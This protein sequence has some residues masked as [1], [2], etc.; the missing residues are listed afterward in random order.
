MRAC[1]VL[2]LPR[3]RG[4][5]AV[6]VA[7]VLGAQAAAGGASA[8]TRDAALAG[9]FQ[10]V[11]YQGYTF[12]VLRNWPVIRL[13]SQPDACVRYDRNA[14]YLGVPSDE[15]SCPALAVGSAE[16]VLIEPGPA[17]SAVSSVLDPIARQIIV[18][19]PGIR[20][21]ATFDHYPGQIYRFLSRASLPDPVA[22]SPGVAGGYAADTLTPDL[23]AP[24]KL[25]V[26]AA[27]DPPLAPGVTDFTGEGFDACTAPSAAVMSTWR[28]L[29]PYQAIGIYLGGSDA[30]CAQPNLTPAWLQTTASEGW[31]FIPMYVGPQAEFGEVNAPRQQGIASAEDAASLASRLGFG[32]Q[33]PLYYDMESYAPSQSQ[34]ALQFLSAWTSTLH[35][36]GYQSGAYSSSSTGIA[37]LARNYSGGTYV[38]PDVVA[39]AWWNGAA[40]TDD[41]VLGTTKWPGHH[42][43]HQF[44]GNITQTYG[45]DTLMIDQDFMDVDLPQ[46]APTPTPTPTPTPSP[47]ASP[48]MS[49]TPAPSVTPT[50][51]PTPSPTP[52]PT[53][54]PAASP[55]SHPTPPSCGSPSS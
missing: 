52:T 1:R 27:T 8:V 6:I 14:V 49:P 51:T 46:P 10:Q 50:P 32:P 2:W 13:A 17:L 55:T 38:M 18:T 42:R 54:T 28:R 21:T 45:G 33:T 15:Q 11:S 26:G 30:A 53:P 3:S 23:V 41:P 43:V 22:E 25:A 12:D 5:L 44:S 4:S 35:S 48:S 24:R 40:N 34:A 9:P 29:S 7:A 37:D 19:A 47:S 31:H 36:L 20:I 39:D 16:S